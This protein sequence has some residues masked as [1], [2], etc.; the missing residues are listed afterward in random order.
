M[1]PDAK[2]RD[3]VNRMYYVHGKNGFRYGKEMCFNCSR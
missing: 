2:A 1:K 3:L